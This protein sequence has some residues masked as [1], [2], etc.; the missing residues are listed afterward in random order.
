MR[1][2]VATD[3]WK[4][5]INGVV[6][7]LEAMAA[8]APALG[9]DLTFISPDMFRSVPMPGY[10]E[11]RLAFASARKVARLI[12]A[13]DP[14]YIHIATE[15]PVGLAARAACRR[16]GRRFTTAYHTRFPE[17]IATRAPIPE[18][19]VY[20]LLRRFHGAGT[21]VLVATATLEQE[22]RARGFTRLSLWTRGVDT[23]LFRPRP[24]VAPKF[25]RPVFLHVGRLA[26]EKNMEA[27]LRLELPGT[28][29]VVGDG[30][31]RKRLEA[32]FPETRFLGVLEGEALAEAYAAADVFVFP[33]RTDTFGMVLLEALASG[34]PI[35]AYPVMGPIDVLGNSGCGVLDEDLGRAALEALSIPGE[36]CRAYAHDFGWARSAQQFL[37]AVKRGGT[38]EARPRDPSWVGALWRRGRAAIGIGVPPQR[39]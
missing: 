13:H 16:Q 18:G 22:L 35:A 17:Y 5:Q 21:G 7:S 33:S 27:F 29:V 12:A 10:P 37:D 8:H 14:D 9:A 32:E 1:I 15:G 11:I 3:A 28:K 30:P 20:R 38:A 23:E 36:R 4:P 19:L 31:E 6:R 34:L 24:D 25:A 26:V 2:L 39:R